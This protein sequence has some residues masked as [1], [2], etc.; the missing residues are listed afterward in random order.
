MIVLFL[1]HRQPNVVKVAVDL[2]SDPA[3]QE[4]NRIPKLHGICLSIFAKSNYCAYGLFYLLTG[5]TQ[6]ILISQK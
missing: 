3:S 5:H 6:K 1:R 2:F 4:N